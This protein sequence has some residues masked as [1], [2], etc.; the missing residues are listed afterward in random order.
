[1]TDYKKMRKKRFVDPKVQGMLLR[2]AARYWFM[3]LAVVGG[4]TVMG[5]VFIS[6]GIGVLVQ[7]RAHLGSLLSAMA[8]AVGVAVL[9]LPIAL[10]DLIRVSSRFVG[11]MHRLRKSMQRAAAGERVDSIKFRDGDVWEEFA[12]AFNALNERLQK[13]EDQVNPG[14]AQ[15]SDET[16]P[17]AEREPAPVG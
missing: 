11:P 14:R 12:D 10:I 7:S 4:V 5:W 15:Q 6:P 17:A 16:K 13:L 1:M 9:L 3:A 8:V 2:H